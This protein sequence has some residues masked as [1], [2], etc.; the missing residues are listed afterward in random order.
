MKLFGKKDN[1]NEKKLIEEL[2]S[3]EE[4]VRQQQS[5]FNYGEISEMELERTLMPIRDGII[6]IKKAIAN[7]VSD[8]EFNRRVHAM[9]DECLR[10][11]KDEQDV[12]GRCDSD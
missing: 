5:A 2:D 9:I 3:L 10:G 7:N 8:E 6:E 4:Y 12:A 1:S 11:C